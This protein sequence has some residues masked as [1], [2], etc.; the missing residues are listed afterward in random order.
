MGRIEYQRNRDHLHE[1][2]TL[3]CDDHDVQ[4]R[5]RNAGWQC[6]IADQWAEGS[7]I[8]EHRDM[9]TLSGAP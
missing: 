5:L 9:Q 6:H 3:S 1:A 2:K 7:S 8:L 4:A